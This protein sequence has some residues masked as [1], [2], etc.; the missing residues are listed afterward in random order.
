[1]CPNK[2][3]NS[4][5]SSNALTCAFSSGPGGIKLPHHVKHGHESDEHEAHDEH[6]RRGD[7]QSRRVVGVEAQHV[8]VAP[9][10]CAATTTSIPSRRG[11][12][13]PQPGT[14]SALRRSAGGRRS[15]N[16]ATRAT[17]AS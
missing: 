16:P 15:R 2:N 13:P 8:V 3:L 14:A 1:M 9:P 7:L 12:S 11:S 10:G 4:E 6:D 5:R 17:P